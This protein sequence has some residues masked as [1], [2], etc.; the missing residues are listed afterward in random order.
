MIEVAE[1]HT[2][3]LRFGLVVEPC[4][5]WWERWHPDATAER[6]ESALSLLSPRGEAGLE[7]LSEAV[8]CTWLVE[9]RGWWRTQWSWHDNWSWPHGTSG[10]EWTAPE[11][12]LSAA[13]PVPGEERW[14][15]RHPG[16]PDTPF[17]PVVVDGVDGLLAVRT[18]TVETDLGGT[19][20]VCG[21]SS[22]WECSNIGTYTFT[23]RWSFHAPRVDAGEGLHEEWR[24]WARCALTRAEPITGNPVVA[25]ASALG[26][27]GLAPSGGRR[28][29]GAHA[30]RL[31]QL[32]DGHVCTAS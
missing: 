27:G 29:M 13:C 14:P 10:D 23:R 12:N 31:R 15:P 3:L 32:P 1:F 6:R 19:E 24:Q 25:S 4:H 22:S 11:F 2:C 18:A 30:S 21:G 5:I 8:I 9:S 20:R 26:R 7:D 28:G 16:L 17:D